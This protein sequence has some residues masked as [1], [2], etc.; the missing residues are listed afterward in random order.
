[1]LTRYQPTPVSLPI[2]AP[3]TREFDDWRSHLPGRPRL[4]DADYEGFETHAIFHDVFI[5]PD[6]LSVR[7]IGPPLV[8][9]ASILKPIQCVVT[10]MHNRVSAPLTHRMQNH[11]R[12]SFHQFSL[13]SALRHQDLLQVH[14]RFANKLEIDVEARRQQ[15][16]PVG[17]QFV[18]LQKNNP[19]A[20]I[21]DWLRYCQEIGV[22]RVILY[23]NGSEKFEDVNHVLQLAELT[24]DL[25][26]IPWPYVYGPVRSFY[27]QFCQASQNNHAH[28]CFA[29]SEW[30]GHFDIDEYLIGPVTENLSAHLRSTKQ[31]TGLLRFDSC[32]VPNVGS[33]AGSSMPSVRDF[34]YRE[35][36][37][38]GKAHKY[39]VRGK[40][41]RMANTHN[42]RLKLGYMRRSVKPEQGMFLH[43][44]ALTT[45]WRP[46]ADRSVSE[47]VDPAK[48]VEDKTVI[49]AL[50]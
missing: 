11:D 13:P 14:L 34:G 35:R 39:I 3:V 23:D 29:A 20:W 12:V 41:L 19:A 31:W 24:I 32:W 47:A 7:A 10:D 43:Y 4:T 44:K 15:L 33:M 30:T 50:G 37:P 26:V 40:A 17:V 2:D 36:S 21:I 28:Q 1:M 8:N 9:L 18:T 46:Y 22:G 48:H 45:N 27:N 5:A 6:G 38:R 25:I 42:G 49:N 16:E